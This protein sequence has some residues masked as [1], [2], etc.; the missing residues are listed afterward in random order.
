[1][2]FHGPT[3]HTGSKAQRVAVQTFTEYVPDPA[4]DSPRRDGRAT[5]WSRLTIT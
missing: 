4:L 2:V 3:S 5:K 1:L